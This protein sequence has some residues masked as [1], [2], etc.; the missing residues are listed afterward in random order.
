[1]QTGRKENGLS[2]V[3]SVPDHSLG[4]GEKTAV[5]VLDDG[6][7]YGV[8]VAVEGDRDG[9]LFKEGVVDVVYS[10]F[11][12]EVVVVVVCEAAYVAGGND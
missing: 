5:A 8:V 9:C 2:N 7:G 6:A 11:G 10:G 12:E 4:H 1:M 3:G